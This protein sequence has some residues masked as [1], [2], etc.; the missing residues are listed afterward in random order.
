MKSLN[1]I[2]IFYVKTNSFVL[3]PPL[4][5]FISKFDEIY[6]DEKSP[7]GILWAGNKSKWI[8]FE[9]FE[10]KEN[11]K[12]KI[13]IFGEK[14]NEENLKNFFKKNKINFREFSCEWKIRN[15]ILRDRIFCVL[16]PL[17]D[18]LLFSYELEK[19][20]GKAIPLPILKMKIINSSKIKNLKENFSYLIF[21]SKRGVIAL[22]EI[23]CLK[24]IFE[25]LKDKKIIAIGPETKKEIENLGFKA[26]IPEEYTQEGILKIFENLEKGK[27]LVLRTEGRELLIKKLRE[28]GFYVKEIKIYKMIEEDEE[29]I[30]IF[31]P[32][33]KNVTD[34]IFTS[35]KIFENFLKRGFGKFLKNK[36]IIAIGKITANYIKNKGFKVDLIPEKF[37]QEGIIEILKRKQMQ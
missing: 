29:K 12:S 23:L 3:F 13:F 22:K 27:V 20:G 5:E 4:W 9:N 18:S 10:F 14:K 21:T 33:L 19:L 15:G 24:E 8:R 17:P 31:L 16:R 34:F 32:F 7:L 2:F 11:N 30:N 26:I 36:R 1:D 35:S 28:F 37:T 25:F 6:F